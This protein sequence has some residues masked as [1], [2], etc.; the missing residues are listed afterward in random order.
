[1]DISKDKNWFL[2]FGVGVFWAIL[3][4]RKAYAPNV[5]IDH[6]GELDASADDYF[7]ER[8]IRDGV[9]EGVAVTECPESVEL[10]C[11]MPPHK[12]NIGG[13][14]INTCTNE[15][16]RGTPFI[17]DCISAGLTRRISRPV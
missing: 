12:W 9:V 11:G 6:Y 15:V 5:H 1:M 14:I 3:T 10:G 8:L 7:G 17:Q 4:S 2:F 16:K 13:K